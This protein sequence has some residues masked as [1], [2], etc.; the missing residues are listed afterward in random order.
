MMAGL[1][2]ASYLSPEAKAMHATLKAGESLKAMFQSWF[3]LIYSWVTS[4]YTAVKI[5][6]LRWS[7]VMI[8]GAEVI[9]ESFKDSATK[10][11]DFFSTMSAQGIN[12]C[13]EWY[14]K[15]LA[16]FND[17][18]EKVK[19]H[20]VPLASETELG[21]KYVD[22]ASTYLQHPSRETYEAANDLRNQ[23]IKAYPEAYGDLPPIE[24]KHQGLFES[25]IGP[26]ILGVIQCCLQ[27]SEKF[28]AVPAGTTARFY[29]T[30]TCLSTIGKI[31]FTKIGSLI[32]VVYHAVTGQDINVAAQMTRE[33]SESTAKLSSLLIELDTSLNPPMELQMEITKQFVRMET[34][35]PALLAYDDKANPNRT[36]LYN[37]LVKKAAPWIA[38]AKAGNRKMKSIAI[39]MFGGAACGKTTA[40]NALVRDVP[41]Q[42]AALF[43][44]FNRSDVSAYSAHGRLASCCSVPCLGKKPEF[45]DGYR[46]QLFYAFEEFLTAKSPAIKADWAN[47]FMKCV[48]GQ[49]YLLNMAYEKG[50]RYFISPF[51]IATSNAGSHHTDFEDPEAYYRRI[52]FDLTVTR[53]HG[54]GGFQ[55]TTRFTPTE[56]M[57]RVY[58][59]EKAPSAFL[60]AYFAEHGFESFNYET[61]LYLVV[62][63]YVNR[64]LEFHITEATNPREVIPLVLDSFSDMAQNIPDGVGTYVASALREACEATIQNAP[65]ISK[66]S[67]D[68]IASNFL[69]TFKNIAA[70]FVQAEANLQESLDRT[71]KVCTDLDKKVRKAFK[72]FGNK[73]KG[74]FIPRVTSLPPGVLEDQP[75]RA[76]PPDAPEEA[77][78]AENPF[79][80]RD[81]EIFEA[82]I[83]QAD[84]APEVPS[85]ELQSGRQVYNPPPI[86]GGRAEARVFERAEAIF[87]YTPIFAEMYKQSAFSGRI[88]GC[89][90]VE[91]LELLQ[92]RSMEGCEDQLSWRPDLM[93]QHYPRNAFLHLHLF[94]VALSAL[95]GTIEA[96]PENRLPG[97]R[98][99]LTTSQWSNIKKNFY[100]VFFH[101]YMAC[102]IANDA[103]H[104]DV[105]FTLALLRPQWSQALPSLSQKEF[106]DLR[107][108][109]R[110]R[111]DKDIAKDGKIYN[112]DKAWKKKYADRLHANQKRTAR[113]NWDRD[114]ARKAEALA[115]EE[116]KADRLRDDDDEFSARSNNTEMQSEKK[117]HRFV[118]QREVDRVE[119]GQRRTRAE[120][121]H[122][123]RNA[124]FSHQMFS[125]TLMP[126]FAPGLVGV[127]PMM[128]R[129]HWTKDTCT[130]EELSDLKLNFVGPKFFSTLSYSE[131]F[132]SPES[133][134]NSVN[135][136]AYLCF[137][138]L[139]HY[140]MSPKDDVFFRRMINIANAMLFD[141]TPEECPSYFL[142]HEKEFLAVLNKFE[143][144]TGI[145][146]FVERTL[147]KRGLLG[148]NV[149]GLTEYA[150]YH[151]NK[152]L[153]QVLIAGMH[154]DRYARDH[155]CI[156]F[157]KRK[158]LMMGDVVQPEIANLNLA[159]IRQVLFMEKAVYH[160]TPEQKNAIIQFTSLVFNDEMRMQDIDQMFV[161]NVPSAYVLPTVMIGVIIL[162][163]P[164]AVYLFD[165]AYNYFKTPITGE[166]EEIGRVVD[167]GKA[168]EVLHQ[169]VRTAAPPPP[170]Q[171]ADSGLAHT[172]R[173]IVQQMGSGDPVINKVLCNSY[174]VVA[175]GAICAS[176]TFLGGTIAHFNAHVWEALPEK[177]SL[178]PY[179]ALPKI[180]RYDVYKP[181]CKVLEV[182][183]KTGFAAISVPH[184]RSHTAITRHV[185]DD[186]DLEKLTRVNSG[187]IATYNSSGDL[188]CQVADD[189]RAVRKTL[190]LTND[191]RYSLPKY[192]M[193]NWAG[194]KAGACGSLL[195]LRVNGN[196]KLVGFHDAGN[197]M[198]KVGIAA[199][200]SKSKVFEYDHTNRTSTRSPKL[201][202]LAPYEYIAL[203]DEAEHYSL[204]F[205]DNATAEFK[206]VV[207]TFAT[208]ETQFKPTPFVD[209]SFMGGPPKIPAHL[210]REAYDKALLKELRNDVINCPYQ[211][212]EMIDR[213]SSLIID[214][215]YGDHVLRPCRTLS[216]EEAIDG[217]GTLNN[218]DK[219]TSKGIRLTHWKMSKKAI[220]TEDGDHRRNFLAKFR[221]SQEKMKLG[222]YE[223]QLNCD[224]L[225]DEPRD[226]ERV[227]L[228]KT[229]LFK[230]TDFVDN[231]HMKCA[232]GDLVEQTHDCHW[233]T[234]PSCGIDPTGSEWRAI[235]E[236]FGED[237]VVAADVGGFESVPSA[238]ALPYFFCLFKR[239]YHSWSLE[240]AIYVIMATFYALRFEFRRNTFLGWQNTSGNWLT[241]WINTHC[242][243]L[244]FSI[245]LISECLI[246]G[247]DP[248]ATLRLLKIK[249]YSDDNIT[250]LAREW[251]TAEFLSKRFKLLFNIDLTGTDKGELTNRKTKIW[252]IDFLS[253]GFRKE[254]GQV[255]APLAFDSLVSQIYFVR[256]PKKMRGDLGF[257]F[258]QL[259]Q[260]LDNVMREL[261]EYPR[262]YAEDLRRKI[263][264]FVRQH[265][266]PLNVADFP[267]DFALAKLARQ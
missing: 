248:E 21:K 49:P 12:V 144:P 238:S 84:E 126:F 216:P 187:I 173:N 105:K 121:R 80:Q 11:L 155:P 231:M 91:I 39:C 134:F 30:V 213:Y 219:D 180:P 18:A 58:S 137:Y 36:H 161:L 262:G 230:V 47:H 179:V 247:I 35:Y 256:V 204:Q 8:H 162:S 111:Y 29:Q 243:M 142:Q 254:N 113:K 168:M 5:K 55:V 177:F 171:V 112:V 160:V 65:L 34:A 96:L 145:R 183:T 72:K 157:Y 255:Y 59:G 106:E 125:S 202:E 264:D 74:A 77:M 2:V 90:Y 218:F 221:E 104:S 63:A 94:N 16:W 210:D 57:K 226:H 103:L 158:C 67:A 159:I 156:A 215:F 239:V 3:E 123:E 127:D 78:D 100:P 245:A 114:E 7:L 251:W 43:S 223:Y 240:Y 175:N 25:C 118:T 89:H 81:V 198:Q 250:S 41:V 44:K 69:N 184:V 14:S 178:V 97:G 214:V 115:K 83:A 207:R 201:D 131:Q 252:D 33:F 40:Q 236:Y 98:S 197:A 185:A 253:R 211:T 93:E 181:L 132:K 186:A 205:L 208:G 193:Y 54:S 244:Y 200:Y 176:A 203:Q 20:F 95:R 182:D 48:D 135:L 149:E 1:K 212:R 222:I 31:D 62:G 165:C 124:K 170:K 227:A 68:K 174:K 242:N 19:K 228:K 88:M 249:L 60:K 107:W 141:E 50:T 220:L 76:T 27:L 148:F 53:M 9:V 259:Q 140:P 99:A 87:E 229:R 109:I 206:P 246:R 150:S 130:N 146:A 61:L 136:A 265:N 70:A 258:K 190:Q 199:M 147:I 153:N 71:N 108:T 169:S 24:V 51:V 119:K 26:L 261:C 189:V 85:L 263:M 102:N 32:N 79:A 234:P 154:S 166:L 17:K 15:I 260:N 224:K 172:L 22:A 46:D 122:N 92:Y 266:L 28:S 52:E 191:G 56:S 151:A 110:L 188:D 120:Q 241:T 225:K 86:E 64:L 13:A 66:S 138:T 133:E 139:I 23:C 152:R 209:H 101:W 192:F 194:A 232:V 37:H 128:M 217:Y 164:M 195:F 6:L 38:S 75:P 117:N 82:L 143:T 257:L 167:A 233:V 235:A 163:I 129:M 10:T 42:L 267:A 237:D 45:D 4:A 116:A 196:V 73:V